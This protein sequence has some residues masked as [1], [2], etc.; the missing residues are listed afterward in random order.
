MT[1]LKGDTG[2]LNNQE[3]ESLRSADFLSLMIVRVTVAFAGMDARGGLSDEIE[4]FGRAAD[5]PDFT[6]HTSK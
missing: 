1:L 2:H 4:K 6:W 5:F 3:P